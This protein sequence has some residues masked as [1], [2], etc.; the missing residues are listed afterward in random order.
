MT[1][2]EK[3]KT[4]ERRDNRFRGMESMLL[5]Q[6]F[7]MKY[8][9]QYILFIRKCCQ[10]SIKWIANINSFINSRVRNRW[11]KATFC[12]CSKAGCNLPWFLRPLENCFIIRSSVYTARCIRF[13]RRRI[14]LTVLENNFNGILA[15]ILTRF[16]PRL[17]VCHNLHCITARFRSWSRGSPR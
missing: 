1:E 12:S 6:C 2:K 9:I 14:P 8:Y 3:K 10:L 13:H 11:N 7:I 16:R 15:K 5:E 17:K 4:R